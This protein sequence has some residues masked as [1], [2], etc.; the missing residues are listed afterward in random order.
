MIKFTIR[1]KKRLWAKL[2]YLTIS[3]LLCIWA[4]IVLN[5]F[6]KYFLLFFQ[7]TLRLAPMMRVRITVT[8]EALIFQS[9]SNTALSKTQRVIMQ[10]EI[11]L[12]LHLPWCHLILLWMRTSSK[13]KN[14]MVRMEKE[15]P[16]LSLNHPQSTINHLLYPR[17]IQIQS[18]KKHFLNIWQSFWSPFFC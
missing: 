13:E 2:R 3:A 17:A 1:T 4:W 18:I 8:L 12:A 7:D 10:G 16:H 14:H 6:I 11:H 15:S 9:S 5:Y